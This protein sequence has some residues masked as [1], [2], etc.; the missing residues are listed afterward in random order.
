[1]INYASKIHTVHKIHGFLWELFSC[2]SDVANLYGQILQNCVLLILARWVGTL[3]LIRY[4]PLIRFIAS[5]GHFSAGRIC[6]KCKGG[7]CKTQFCRKWPRGF[8]KPFCAWITAKFE[9]PAAKCAR[10]GTPMPRPRI[11]S[12]FLFCLRATGTGAASLTW[13]EM[14]LKAAWNPRRV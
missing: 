13:R 5:C 14:V 11:N 12:T 8:C 6:K 1:M 7:F 9:K 2:S 3:P 10:F 4:K